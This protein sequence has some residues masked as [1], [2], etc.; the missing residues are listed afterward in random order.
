MNI[1]VGLKLG[2]FFFYNITLNN[3]W[4]LFNIFFKEK[5]WVNRSGKLLIFK[6]LK[7][8]LDLE[9]RLHNFSFFWP[10]IEFL[11]QNY[12]L[13]LLETSNLLG[14]WL[15]DIFVSLGLW[16]VDIIVSLKMA[17][18]WSTTTF[19]IISSFFQTKI[20]KIEF[21]LSKWWVNPDRLGLWKMNVY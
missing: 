6:T 7:N 21:F 12:G 4:L 8:V 16:Q 3:S 17:C 10:N 15:M 19:Y 14:H 13:I 1:V 18:S 9:Q 20:E 5:L 11:Y 2:S